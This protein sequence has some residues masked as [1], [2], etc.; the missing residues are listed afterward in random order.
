MT[1]SRKKKLLVFLGLVGLLL[2]AGIILALHQT[3]SHLSISEWSLCRNEKGGY[4]INYPTGWHVYGEGSTNK[5][6][7]LVEKETPCYGDAVLISARPVGEKFPGQL[8]P[9]TPGFS[10]SVSDQ[11]RLKGTIWDG[12]TNLDTYLKAFPSESRSKF[13]KTTFANEEAVW[14]DIHGPKEIRFFHNDRLFQVS[15]GDMPQELINTI[16]N[17]FQFLD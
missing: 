10:I 16:Y 9:H 7:P 15:G 6:T 8:T 3:T 11:E 17:S 12:A 4:Q 13:H 5:F 1:S 2:G 14:W